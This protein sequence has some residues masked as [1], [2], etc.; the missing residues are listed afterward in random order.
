MPVERFYLQ[1]PLEK[2][3]LICF[4]KE[5]LHHLAHVLRMK[6]KDKL[7]V[8]NGEGFLANAYLQTLEKNKAICKIE[9]VCYTPPPSYT[10]I[11]AQA[12]PRQPKLEII[13]EKSV[14]LG[15][16]EL[17]LFP[18][19][20]S[21]KDSFSPSGTQRIFHIVQSA[22][23]QCGRLYIPKV[24]FLP[25]LIKWK[26]SLPLCSVFGDIRQGAPSFLSHLSKNPPP[27][28]LIAIGPEKGFDPKEVSFM[29]QTLSMQGVH[30]HHNI[31]RTETAALCSLSIASC[32]I[33]N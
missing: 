15:I 9:S 11:L 13:V 7:E 3:S 14:E 21:E 22:V 4:E 31:L 27:S 28:L 29:E 8:I 33:E 19:Q 23:K 26:E 18:G 6:P 24:R 12:I 32:F 1:T 20:R 2:D 10:L 16:T 17:W 30:L 25:P 5:E